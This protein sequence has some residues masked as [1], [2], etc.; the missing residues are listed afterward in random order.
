[1]R[2]VYL[3][4]CGINSFSEKAQIDFQALLKGGVFGIFGD[5]GSGKSTILDS[6]HFALYGEIDRAPKSFDSCI[7]HRTDTASVT[8]DFEITK[9]GTKKLYRVQRE[10]KRAGK[11]KASFYE[12]TVDNKWLPI[13]EGARDVDAEIENT[14][15][16]T[17]ADFKT[18]IA[19]PQGDFATLV[20]ATPAERIKL[21][22]RLF[23]LEKYG[24]R[25]FKEVSAKYYKAEEEVNLVKAR[26]EE[27]DGANEERLLAIAQEIKTA[28]AL[29]EELEKQLVDA[30]K[31]VKAEQELAEKKKQW[32][33]LCI[34]LQDKDRQLDGMKRLRAL[35]EQQPVLTALSL[36]EKEWQTAKTNAEENRALEQHNARCYQDAVTLQKQLEEGLKSRLFDDEILSLS[37]QYQQAL[38]MQKDLEN[39][40][41][42]KAALDNCIA[43]YTKIK[44]KCQEE[45]FQGRLSALETQLNALGQDET[46]LDYLKHAYKDV[47]MVDVYGEF[48]ADLHRLQEKHPSIKADVDALLQKYA[49]KNAE[50]TDGIDVAQINLSFKAIQQKRKALKDE[51]TKIEQRRLLFEQNENEKK[52]LIQQGK[53]LRQNYE[54]AQKKVAD[55]Q[56]LDA[57]ARLEEKLAQVKSQKER[58]QREWEKVGQTVKETFATL[59]KYQ[60]LQVAFEKQA[61]EK[62]AQLQR[63][64]Q[65]NGFENIEEVRLLRQTLEKSTSKAQVDAFFEEYAL[66]SAEYK[67]IDGKIFLGY[68]ENRLTISKAEKTKISIARDDALKTLVNAQA[69]EKRLF[70]LKEKYKDLQAQLSQKEER[71]ETCD[72]LR[73]LLKGN[74]FLEFIAS[75]YLQ[76]ICS[77]AGKTLLSLTNGRYFLKYEEKEFKVGDNLDGGNV[78]TVK[79]LSG[80]ETFLV[81]LSLALSLSSAICLKSLRPIEFFFLDEGFGTLDGKLVDTVMDVLG[82]LSKTFAVGLISH[83]EELKHRIDNKIEVTGATETHGSTVKVQCF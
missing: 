9:D 11:S 14:V 68:D 74:K 57:P 46:L 41:T 54:E 55:L 51:Q 30:E 7:N 70:T 40:R 26:M 59:Q 35:W 4:F 8:F 15:G 78:R 10:R 20:K 43:E 13:A 12:Y 73:Q 39:A 53:L 31:T 72:K 24:E 79:T 77:T 38:S 36:L 2:P 34:K 71:R 66:L 19:L 17:F 83:V 44:D 64:L 1:M 29:L 81:S 75:E 82:K 18:C 6:I 76:E 62:F 28:S 25:L 32:D 65:E 52:L 63:E 22:A 80:G 50:Q 21:V 61:T 5:T 45:D 42:A 49:V 69:E 37:L 23:D 47:L 48:R 56:R 60:G 27:N 3:E 16:L 33:T 67:K 58:A